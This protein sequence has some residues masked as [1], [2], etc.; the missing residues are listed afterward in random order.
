M[1]ISITVRLIHMLSIV[2][3]KCFV[4]YQDLKEARK[5]KIDSA[6]MWTEMWGISHT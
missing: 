2:Y 4:A 6:R 3:G 1:L 5:K